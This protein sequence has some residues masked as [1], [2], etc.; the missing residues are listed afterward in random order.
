MIKKYDGYLIL[1][2]Y[3]KN[4]KAKLIEL[5]VTDEVELKKQIS[6]SK[7]G[8]LG[9][10]LSENGKE[11]TFGMLKAIFKD[12]IYAKKVTDLKKGVF[13]LVPILGPLALVPFFPIIAVV[14]AIF[15]TSRLFH[16]IFDIVFNYLEPQS[17]YSDFLKKMI[18]TYMKIP[19][20]QVNLKDRFSR[21]FVVSDRLID[22][23]K[24]EVM[25]DFTNYLS[26]K[27]E[28]EDDNTRVPDHYIQNELKEYLNANFGHK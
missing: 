4:I 15:G 16:K 17:R 8:H 3:D 6:L 12:A 13:G 14:S 2:K 28:Q 24:P 25:N 19:E 10:Y 18:D 27:M 20:G 22:A 1:E 7:K 21:A 9:H 11:F 26:S 5:G 23:I